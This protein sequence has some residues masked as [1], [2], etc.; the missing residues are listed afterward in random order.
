VGV[1]FSV[2]LELRLPISQ[3]QK[4]SKAA[5]CESTLVLGSARPQSDPYL[6]SGALE[7]TQQTHVMFEQDYLMCKRYMHLFAFPSFCEVDTR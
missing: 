6:A 4:K 2:A 7:A 3:R 1:V 5:L